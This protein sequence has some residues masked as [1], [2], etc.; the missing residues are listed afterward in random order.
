MNP[1]LIPEIDP[2]L[3]T[4]WFVLVGV[5]FTG[6]A[7]LDGF[8]LGVVQLGWIRVLRWLANVAC[9]PATFGRPVFDRSELAS[10]PA[11]RQTQF[12]S[13]AV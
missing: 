5:L 7:M 11:P 1:A 10:V 4:V 6:Y 3:N 12:P 2:T 8:D 13:A 9:E